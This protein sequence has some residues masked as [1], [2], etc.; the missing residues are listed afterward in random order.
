MVSTYLYSNQ[1]Y[2][3]NVTNKNFF[4]L[5]KVEKKKPLSNF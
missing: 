5:K 3:Y 4:D 1:L 2:S